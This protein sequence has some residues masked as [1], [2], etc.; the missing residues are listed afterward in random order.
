MKCRVSNEVIFQLPKTP[1][2][3]DS[4]ICLLWMEEFYF[5]KSKQSISLSL[6]T[7][8]VTV[9]SNVTGTPS[10]RGCFSSCSLTSALTSMWVGS[11]ELQIT[12]CLPSFHKM[13]KKRS[14]PLTGVQINQDREGGR[15]VFIQVSGHGHH[16]LFLCFLLSYFPLG[17][18]AA[19]S[20]CRLPACAARRRRCVCE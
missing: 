18:P 8:K 11:E 15:F 10:G 14:H 4:Y 1:Y 20:A 7:R 13:R 16:Q 3:L 17:S 12:L 5:L 9:H 19:A 2:T 6:L